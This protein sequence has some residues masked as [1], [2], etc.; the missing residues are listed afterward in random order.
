ME[1]GIVS[2]QGRRSAIL[3]I[4]KE[5]STVSVLELSKMFEVSEVTI[6]KDLNML[7]ERNLLVRT[8][9]G[10]IVNSTGP[11]EDEKSIRYKRLANYR[12]KQA[13]GR[14]AAELIEEGDTVIIDS[15]TTAFQVACNL[16][17]F[18]NLTILTNALNV[19]QEVLSY[20]RFNVIL[21][22]GNIRNSSESVVGALAESNLKMFYCDKLFLGVDSFSLDNGLSTPSVEE[23]N[24][25]QIM[26]QRSRKVITVFDSSKVN[27]R[28][29]AFITSLDNID[30]IVTD[31]G[32]E[33]SFISQLKARNIEVVTV[34][35]DGL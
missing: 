13:I 18:Q 3:Q 8:R 15:G 23:A 29:L 33:K 6:R 2:S 9:G 16:H 24:I 1:V 7:K 5:N 12:E 19:A 20:N 21:L 26:I 25:N 17:R 10:A 27:K 14:A 35:P 30:T 4:L 28:A 34:R 11:Q 31:D 32:M 22:G